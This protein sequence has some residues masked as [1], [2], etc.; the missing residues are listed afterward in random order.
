MLIETEVVPCNI[1]LLLSKESLKRADTVIDVKED[2]VTMFSQP[3]DITF[4]SSGHYCVSILDE[5]MTENDHETQVV[6]NVNSGNDVS[7]T[8]NTLTKL[9]RQ[10]GHASSERLWKLLKST[11]K[12]NNDVKE[13]LDYVVHKCIVCH[14]FKR[15]GPKPAVAFAH[16]NDFNQIVALDLHELDKNLYYLH[17]IDLFSRLSAASI[18]RSKNPEVITNEFMKIWVGIYGSPEVGVY[19]DNGGEFNNDIFLSMAENLN[20]SVKTTA[21]YSPWSNGVCERHNAVI[22]ETLLKVRQSENLSWETALI[23]ATHAKNCLLNVY[24]FSPFQIVYG[25]NPNLPSNIVNKP[26]ALESSDMGKSMANHLK[27]LHTTRAAFIAA[28]SSEKVKR[29][30]KHKIRPRDSI[31][32]QGDKVYFERNGNWKGPGT[33][34]GQD[35]AV[36]FVRYGGT[37]VRVHKSKLM[38]RVFVSPCEGVS[39]PLR[40][41]I[42]LNLSYTK[43]LI[44]K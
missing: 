35:S 32:N 19:T 1:P 40:S 25:R 27:A 44:E 15:A 4:T 5:S 33:V 36:V 21:A 42:C 16:A 17:V 8:R 7:L 3:I 24:G 20:I 28:E 18:I 10:F 30:L 12:V 34:I 22:T 29:A 43:V 37:Y 13:L 39:V 11:G 9:H 23:W 14:K 26:P 38:R 2:K 41:K 6:L 31:F